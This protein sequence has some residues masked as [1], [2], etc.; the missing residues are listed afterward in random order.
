MDT[1]KSDKEAQGLSGV[2]IVTLAAALELG[3]VPGPGEVAANFSFGSDPRT[4][5]VTKRRKKAGIQ[6]MYTILC[7]T[8]GD[9]RLM[10][11]SHFVDV[12][13]EYSDRGMIQEASRIT[14]FW[15]E[16]QSVSQDNAVLVQYLMEYFKK[17]TG[18]GI[19]V[20]VDVL[21][22]QRV[23]GS[24]GTSGA[25]GAEM[26]AFRD[27][28]KS[29]RDELKEAK[30]DLASV[31]AELGRVKSNQGPRPGP[32]GATNPF[33]NL[34][35]HKCGEKGHKA[36]DCPNRKKKVVEDEKEDEDE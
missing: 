23:L 7:D 10:L 22:A 29:V 11:N 14:Q 34:T 27:S 33:A 16:T 25:S 17:Y 35:C 12:V 18:R 26:T 21:V 3:K 20:I 30:R 32:G 13:R 2:R 8:K 9:V 4:A 19:P 15:A 5:D 1:L 36:A 24:R 28:L 31:K 6:T